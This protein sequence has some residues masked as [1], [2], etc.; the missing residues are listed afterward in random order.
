MS[1]QIT[2]LGKQFFSQGLCDARGVAFVCTA[3][4]TPFGAVGMVLLT[5]KENVL[6]IYGYSFQGVGELLCKVPL[7]E[8]EALKLKADVLHMLLPGDTLSFVWQGGSFRFTNTGK[9]TYQAQV[10]REE[11]AKEKEG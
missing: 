9:L 7:R 5:V 2:K 10:I 11:S 8:I 1:D 4:E 3:R 6:R